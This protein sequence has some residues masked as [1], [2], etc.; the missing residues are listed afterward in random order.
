[1]LSWYAPVV[2]PAV[3]VCVGVALVRENDGRMV[4][5]NVTVWLPVASCALNRML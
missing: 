1:M 2:C 5:T 4:S 3:M